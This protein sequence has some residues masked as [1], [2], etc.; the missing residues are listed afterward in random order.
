MEHELT[1]RTHSPTEYHEALPAETAL[2]DGITLE[3]VVSVDRCGITYSAKQEGQHFCIRE[4]FPRQ[5]AYRAEDGHTVILTGDVASQRERFRSIAAFL[6]EPHRH[7]P[8]CTQVLEKNGT[9]YCVFPCEGMGSL[10]KAAP[11]WT[12]MYLHSIALSLCEAFSALHGAGFCYGMLCASDIWLNRKGTLLLLPDRLFEQAG[13]GMDPLQDMHC[14]T[15]FLRTQLLRFDENFEEYGESPVLPLLR[16]VLQYVYPDVDSLREAL[17]C[18]NGHPAMPD[19]SRIGKKQRVIAVICAVFLLV[20]VGVSGYIASLPKPLSALISSQEI[21]PGSIDVWIPLDE[22]ADEARMQV[23]YERLTQGFERKYPGFGIHLKLF[24]DG[25]FEETMQN[26]SE[27]TVLPTVFMNTEH[28]DARALAADLSML[29][30]ELGSMYLLDMERFSEVLP[31][32]CSVPV[33]YAHGESTGQVTLEH[34]SDEIL[35]DSS[36]HELAASEPNGDFAEFLTNREQCILASSA[37]IA[38][39][40]DNPQTSGAVRIQVPVT[41][42]SQIPLLLEMPCILN[43]HQDENSRYIGMLWLQYLLTEEAQG[44]LFAENFGVLPLHE[45]A[46]DY[47]VSQHEVFEGFSEMKPQFTID[48]LEGK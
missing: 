39:M 41:N 27:T 11:A 7:L 26:R 4:W 48:Y 44:I 40:Q 3:S 17:L 16:E 12:P 37:Y 32:G 38:S 23:I 5:Q 31:L 10:E 18:A 1:E 21:A 36:V 35:Y 13:E 9:L 22:N 34:P 43:N 25:S 29:T 46:F 33:L 47:V 14:L 30:S 2:G 42:E 15:A 24:A 20:S 8:L 6:Q 28:P 19:K 45:Q